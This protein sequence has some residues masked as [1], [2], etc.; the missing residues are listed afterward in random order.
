MQSL[1]RGQHC[2]ICANSQSPHRRECAVYPGGVQECHAAIMSPGE[3]G[4]SR[5][6][7]TLHFF[8][9]CLTLRP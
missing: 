2:P 6:M 3:W 5:S 1:K 9:I 8:K 7:I 4:S